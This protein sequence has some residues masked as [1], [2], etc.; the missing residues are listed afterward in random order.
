M[1]NWKA[2]YSD[3]IISMDQAVREIRSGD[4]IVTSMTTGIPV[5][6]LDTLAEY[7]Q[8]LSDV[9]L[10]SIGSTKPSIITEKKYNK[11]IQVVSSFYM[12][13]ERTRRANGSN[14]SYQAIHFSDIFMD[15]RHL[16]VPNVAIVA[17][18]PPD[19]NGLISLGTC[20][21]EPELIDL[22]ER[23]YVQINDNIPYVYSNS[24]IPADKV[25]GFVLQNEPLSI[26]IEP[27]IS[28]V[29]YKISE[30]IAE[31]VPD[32]ACIQLGIGNIGTALGSL[33]TYKKHLGIHTEM[34][35][36]SMANLIKCGAVDNSCKNLCKGKTVFGFATGNKD[37]YAFLERNKDVETRPFSWVNDPRIISQN[38]NVVS[39]NSAL[40]IDLSGQ[41]CAESIGLRHY[42]GTGGQA[43][44][45]R[46]AKWSKGGMSF[47]AFPSSRI[48]KEG[49]HHSRISLALPLGGVV[50][51]PRSDVQFIVTEY[52]IA[53]LRGATLDERAERLIA[54]AHPKFRDELK[55]EA[56]SAGLII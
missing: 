19:E 35:T 50:T 16:H 11:H 26:T 23:V 52:G 5:A 21:I 53:D 46:G 28:E 2:S 39:V 15:R 13:M 49:K 31:Q 24:L 34:L 38:D 20:A 32:G 10:Y 22:V 41:V 12:G 42:S 3:K 17:G 40:Q 54:I 56:K 27:E 4:I 51:T 14:V 33:L 9:K 7:S 29:E 36:E 18:T 1:N 47:I 43:D 30:Y 37:L 8:N 45:V 6:F 44:Y 48:D 25:T 55:T